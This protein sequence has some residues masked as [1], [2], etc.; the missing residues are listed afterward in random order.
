MRKKT[1]KN[2]SRQNSSGKPWK[3]ALRVNKP[4]KQNCRI[5]SLSKSLIKQWKSGWKCIFLMTNSKSS[6]E[7]PVNLQSHFYIRMGN[8]QKRNYTILFLFD[9]I[10]GS[11][12]QFYEDIAARV[13]IKVDLDFGESVNQINANELNRLWD[14][15]SHNHPENHGPHN[16]RAKEAETGN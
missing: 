13:W 12:C 14:S 8:C 5:N 4:Q 2:I 6:P 1:R 11:F 10:W 15:E 3:T 9:F 7:K 16:C